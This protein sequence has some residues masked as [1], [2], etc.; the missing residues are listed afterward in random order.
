MKTLFREVGCVLVGQNATLL[1]SAFVYIIL[2]TNSE[3]NGF[4]LSRRWRIERFQRFS[5]AYRHL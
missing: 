4:L 2:D 1:H 3:L 5:V